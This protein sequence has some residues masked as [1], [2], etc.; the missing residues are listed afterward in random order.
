MV[1]SFS[2]MSMSSQAK[3]AQSTSEQ[4]IF[5][6]SYM[7]GYSPMPKLMHICII[8]WLCLLPLGRMILEIPENIMYICSIV[9]IVMSSLGL[10][11]HTW[12]DDAIPILSWCWLMLAFLSQFFTGSYN[13]RPPRLRTKIPK[14]QLSEAIHFPLD[15]YSQTRAWDTY[16]CP[17]MAILFPV[18]QPRLCTSPYY[19]E[20][21]GSIY[22]SDTKYVPILWW[23]PLFLAVFQAPRATPEILG[24]NPCQWEQR[25]AWIQIIYKL[26]VAFT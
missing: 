16:C 21:W 18:S 11:S 10:D 23:L 14:T 22:V 19:W 15:T 1:L 5:T 12:L 8:Y 17:S 2:E 4:E 25:R 7:H 3:E 20:V 9:G 24:Y 6:H 13:L 26:C